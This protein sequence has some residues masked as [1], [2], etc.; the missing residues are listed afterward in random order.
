M[1]KVIVDE[2][3][4]SKK[5]GFSSVRFS[6]SGVAKN[7]LQ[8]AFGSSPNRVAFQT[9]NNAV[10]SQL[11]LAKGS[12]VSS[13]I[14][15]ECRIVIIEKRASEIAKMPENVAKG[16][17]PKLNPSTKQILTSGGETV[18]SRRSVELAN[19]ADEL[20]KHDGEKIPSTELEK[21]AVAKAIERAKARAATAPAAAQLAA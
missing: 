8:I 4:P 13:A 9:M 19:V 6:Q 3:R 16:Y 12:D 2:I 18:F 15:Q 11:G 7:F 5:D 1:N 17:Q 10:I 20:V 14:G 21:A